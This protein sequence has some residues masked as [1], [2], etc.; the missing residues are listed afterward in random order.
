MLARKGLFIVCLISL[1]GGYFYFRPFFSGVEEEPTILD[2]LPTGDFLGRVY[3]LDVA[4]ETNSFLY[5]NKLPFRDFLTSEFLLAQGKNYG[6]N[7]QKPVYFFSNESGEWGSIVYVSDSSKILA[8]LIRIKQNMDLEDTLVGGQKVTKIPKENTYMTYG[9]NWL[10]TYHGKQLPKR[11]YHV[12]YSK[13][14]DIHPLWKDFTKN[15]QFKN[16]SIVVYSNWEKIKINGIEKA[17]FSFDCDS[18]EFH[19]KTYFKSKEPLNLSVKDSGMALVPKMD[20]DKY[21]S[22]HLNVSKLRNNPSDPLVKWLTRL[23]KR[24]SFPI[25]DFF[26]AW[27]GDLTL[28][29]GGLQTIKQSYIETEFDEEFNAQEV[30]KEK[31]VLV[32]GYSVLLSMNSFQKEFVSNLFAK[33]IMRKENNRFHILTS[34]PLHINQKPNYLM[35][36]SSDHAPKITTNKANKGYWKDQKTKYFFNLDSLNNQEV[37]FSVHFPAISLLRK[38]KFF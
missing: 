29:E 9:K 20:M 26:K 33:G 34:P 27:E 36:Y 37:Y 21:L 24:V 11:M 18:I 19:L 4:R 7:L 13:K 16:E 22:L 31:E 2:R 6:L 10:F 8:G 35:L 23:G 12:I 28:Q 38:N 25:N 30:R 17:M 32:P 5:Y 15:K 1:I 14:N 3:V